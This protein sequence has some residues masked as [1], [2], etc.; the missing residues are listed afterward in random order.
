MKFRKPTARKQGLKIL[1]Y[2][3]NN[4]GKSVFT[5][6]FP[7][8]AIV[9]SES[10]IGVYENDPEFKGNILGIADTANY[11]DTISLAK[12][13]VDNPNTFHT[14]TV[15]S[16]TN[17]YNGMQVAAMENEEERAKKKKRKVDDTT[18]SQRGW[19]KVKLNIMRLEEFITQASAQGVTFIAVAH[20]KDVYEGDGDD[21]HKIGVRPDLGKNAEHVFDVIIH[22]FKRKDIASGKWKFVAQI[23][24]DT[25]RTY[26]I[27]QEFDKITY[28][29]FKSYIERSNNS[30]TIK[31][32][33]DKSIDT[34]I[35]TLQKESEDH[36]SIVEEFKDL[37]KQAVK[38]DADNKEKVMKLLK[39]NNAEKYS[40]PANNEA[41]KAVIEEIKKLM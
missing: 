10:K 20:E 8:N 5:L 22:F 24:K 28:D 12:D 15:D 2:G 11:Y 35:E 37:Y 38:A 31:T 33:Y 25:T 36:D 18:I 23:D 40:D 1:A 4:T 27:G 3:Q 7:G 13:V 19:G 32:S 41:L 21:R 17:V 39:D 14:F 9:D 26:E 30:E 34:N 16:Y 29:A 6:T